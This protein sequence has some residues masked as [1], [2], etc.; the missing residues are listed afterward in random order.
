MSN[1]LKCDC[2][3]DEIVRKHGLPSGRVTEGDGA[4]QLRPSFRRRFVSWLL[5]GI[6]M[7]R[8]RGKQKFVGGE[9]KTRHLCNDCYERIREEIAP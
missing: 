1:K 7:Q 5:G 8:W 6:T 9:W 3:G 4:V 2:C